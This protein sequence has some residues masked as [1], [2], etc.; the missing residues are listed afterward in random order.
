MIQDQAAFRA[1]TNPADDA[2][3]SSAFDSRLWLFEWDG[4]TSARGLMANDDS[5]T[6]GEGSLLT[7]PTAFPGVN[8]NAQAPLEQE[9]YVLVVGG[10]GVD[11]VDSEGTPLVPFSTATESLWGFAAAAFD[12]WQTTTS[13]SGAYVVALEGARSCSENLMFISSERGRGDLST[14]P[15]AAGETGLTAG[16]TVCNALADAAELPGRYRALLSTPTT[17]AACRLLD[18]GAQYPTCLQIG[19]TVGGSWQGLD[20]SLLISDHQSLFDGQE[21]FAGLALDENGDPGPLLLF[22]GSDGSGVEVPGESCA[23]FESTEGRTSSSEVGSAGP[24]IFDSNLQG[25]CNNHQS[26]ICAQVGRFPGP[27]RLPATSP[28]ARKV[29]LT[30]R[31][32]IGDFGAWPGAAP[33]QGVAAADQVCVNHATIAELENPERFVAWLSTDSLDARDRLDEAGPWARVDGVVVASSLADLVS[34]EIDVALAID[35]TGSA[36]T[37]FFPVVWTGTKSDGTK[38]ANNC[39]NWTDQT[40]LG[41]VGEVLQTNERWTDA[42]LRACSSQVGSLLCFE[43]LPVADPLFADDFET[44]DTS[45]W[46]AIIGP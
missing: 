43:G 19:A 38:D 21:A 31:R 15:L 42:S 4:E 24:A 6:G 17:D 18:L 41:R 22:S 45:I 46:S 44:G 20:G 29:F 27:E 14:W 30:S 10:V 12:R 36:Q 32:D 8:E 2:G 3:A 1:T 7:D 26:L 16:D 34:G 28:E 9:R 13:S 39:G 25:S 37:D 35:E 40:A 33:K 5:P 11:A 23:G